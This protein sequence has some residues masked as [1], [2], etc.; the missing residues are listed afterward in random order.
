MRVGRIATAWSASRSGHAGD[1]A[2]TCAGRWSIRVAFALALLGMLPLAHAAYLTAKAGLA[3]VL[4]ERAW[5]RARND[6]SAAKPWP[7]ADT[8]PVARLRVKRLGIDQIVLSGDSGRTLAFGPGWRSSSAQPGAPG[9]AVISGH[10]DTHFSYLRHIVRGDEM[11][12]ET[13]RGTTRYRVIDTQ[14]VDSRRRISPVANTPESLLLVT[15]Y[16]F[17]AIVPGGPLRYVV[18][19]VAEDGATER[20]QTISTTPANARSDAITAR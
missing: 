4:L 18:S 19:A 5:Q 2:R 12:L 14:V 6:D 7:W 11:A 8:S 15:C 20:P 17:D 9:L 3:Q 10:R 16:P 1:P 13:V